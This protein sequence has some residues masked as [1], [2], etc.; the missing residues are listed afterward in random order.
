M[1]EGK[2]ACCR[3][4]LEMNVGGKKFRSQRNKVEHC[5]SPCLTANVMKK[6]SVTPLMEEKRGPLLFNADDALAI[7]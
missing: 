2:T 5:L 1:V 6:K 7:T 4:L 3:V